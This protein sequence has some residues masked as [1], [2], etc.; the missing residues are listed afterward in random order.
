V[1]DR[2]DGFGAG[3]ER[4]VGPMYPWLLFGHLLGVVL[5]VTG[6]GIYVASV[7]GYRRVQSVAQLRTLA[8]LTVVG[9][10]VLA[11]GGL[12]LIGFGLVLAAKFY[13]FSSPWILTA[14]GLVVLQGFSGAAL[15]GP[16][17]HRLHAA[18]TTVSDGSPAAALTA[19]TRDRVLHVAN[20]ASIPVLLDIEF[21]MTVKPAAGDIILSLVVVTV[22]AL[23]LSWPILSDRPRRAPPLPTSGG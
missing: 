8:G 14:L 23:A 11:A 19:Q 7:D 10:R 18:L 22:T 9:E 20:R 4:K 16:R 17:A 5:F 6:W 12:L 21:L 3:E 13:S 15:V 1:P 2:G